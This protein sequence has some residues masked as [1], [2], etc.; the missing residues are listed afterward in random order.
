MQNDKSMKQGDY[1]Y[2]F[3]SM[4]ISVWKW[5][6]NRIIYFINNLHGSNTVTVKNTTAPKVI[7]DYNKYMGAVNNADCLRVAYGLNRRAKKWWHKIFCGLIDVNFV[8]S[9]VIFS[10]LLRKKQLLEFRRSVALGLLTQKQLP[11]RKRSSKNSD[12]P[13]KR[14]KNSQRC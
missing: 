12:C 4:D 2:R 3:S 1:D 5:K 10:G 13:K 11:I 7:K 9:Y 8:N 14:R 6:D